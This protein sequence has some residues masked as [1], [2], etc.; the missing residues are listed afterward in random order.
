MI[1]ETKPSETILWRHLKS[2]PY[3]R[4]MVRAIEDRFYQ[5]LELPGPTLDLGSGDGH[6]ASVAFSRPLDVGIDPWWGPLLESRHL[7]AYRLLVQADGGKMPFPDGYFGS[8]VS[9]SVLEHIPHVEQVLE[10]VARVVRPG[11]RFVFCV[12][13]H[14]FPQLLLGRRVFSKL[15]WKAAAEGYSR[16]FNRISRHQHCDSPQVWQERLA[17]V[18][19]IIEKHWDYF[20]ADALHRMEVGHAL[21]IPALVSKKIFGRW[22]LAPAAWN[23][24]LPYLIA[25]KAFNS[26]ITESGVYSFYIAR[27]AVTSEEKMPGERPDQG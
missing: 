20:D 7:G 19:F 16:L 9:N 24:F 6:F 2:L 5:G 12:P 14:R 18:G 17:R 27:R 1:M 4:A 8:V 11:G 21:G 25:R 26:P 15:G 23:L 13:N 3:F 10:E 22:V